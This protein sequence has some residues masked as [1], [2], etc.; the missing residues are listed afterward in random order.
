VANDTGFRHE[1]DSELI[2]SAEI[3]STDPQTAVSQPGYR[4]DTGG[5]H[6][7]RDLRAAKRLLKSGVFTLGTDGVYAREGKRRSFRTRAL[8][9]AAH[10]AGGVN[11][12]PGAGGALKLR[13]ESAP[14][15]LT[16]P[17]L[18]RGDFDIEVFYYGK[19]LQGT[20]N[21][22]RPGNRWAY[23]SPRPNELIQQTT[24]ELD[25]TRNL[26]LIHEADRIRWEDLPIVP[27]FEVP[28]Y[29]AVRDT[30]VNVVQNFGNPASIFW[31]APQWGRKA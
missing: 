25:D 26:P 31:N 8:T 19:T 10:V 28:L 18:L 21:Q 22:L 7:R 12:G 15:Q 2:V 17:Q 11:P 13:I 23:P 3:T 14:F 9:G 6:D 29:L 27:L 20:V 24:S 16:G 5:R 1:L 30:A 4:D